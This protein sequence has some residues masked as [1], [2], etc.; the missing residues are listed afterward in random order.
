MRTAEAIRNDH[1]ASNR[2][3]GLGAYPSNLAA[4]KDDFQPVTRATIDLYQRSLVN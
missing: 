3:D 2:L 4:F 1:A